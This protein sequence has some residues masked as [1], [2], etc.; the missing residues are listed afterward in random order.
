MFLEAADS[1]F[2]TV[3]AVRIADLKQE[4]LQQFLRAYCSLAVKQF[5]EQEMNGA[6]FA[7]W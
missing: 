4:K 6:I 7:A 2:A 5:V 1:P 3:I